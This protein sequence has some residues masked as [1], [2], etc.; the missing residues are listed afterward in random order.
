[1]GEKEAELT[2]ERLLALVGK[3]PC[4]RSVRVVGEERKGEY[5]GWQESEEEYRIRQAEWLAEVAGRKKKGD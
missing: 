4:V 3:M 1:M 5:S 2:R